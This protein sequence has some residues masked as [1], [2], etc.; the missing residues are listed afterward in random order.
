MASPERCRLLSYLM[1]APELPE[2]TG[3]AL[4]RERGLKVPLQA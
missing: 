2:L 1:Q 3:S 4:W